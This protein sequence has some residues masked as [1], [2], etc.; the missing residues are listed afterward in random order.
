MTTNAELKQQYENHKEE[1]KKSGKK[2]LKFEKWYK[3]AFKTEP[4]SFVT[5]EF[6]KKD[7]DINEYLTGVL[8][9]EPYVTNSK[10]RW[11]FLNSF[12]RLVHEKKSLNF[13]TI[14]RWF[15]RNCECMK[16]RT[17]KEAYVEFLE[18]LG[19][20]GWDEN[21]KTVTWKGDTFEDD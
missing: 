8:G 19:V 18:T 11:R 3:Q 2:A 21:G 1:S 10:R 16:P 20:L 12:A 13:V 4:P 14:V 9:R 7:L 6:N 15:A 5:A 17:I